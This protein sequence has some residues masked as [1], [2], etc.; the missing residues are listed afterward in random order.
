[1][2]GSIVKTNPGSYSKE[3]NEN[4]GSQMGNTKKLFFKSTKTFLVWLIN[5]LKKKKNNTVQY[6]NYAK[7]LNL[8]RSS[9]SGRRLKLRLRRGRFPDLLED[10]DI[11][12]DEAVL[13]HRFLV[14]R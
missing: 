9:S 10:E 6:I 8:Q 3:K 5:V 2:L 13:F 4:M 11:A 12:V 1:M 14:V 7:F